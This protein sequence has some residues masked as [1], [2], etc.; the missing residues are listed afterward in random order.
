MDWRRLRGGINGAYTLKPLRKAWLVVH[1]A[2]MGNTW[3]FIL[4]ENY[5]GYD[6]ESKD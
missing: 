6:A 5:Q 4:R 1:M 2:S 3:G